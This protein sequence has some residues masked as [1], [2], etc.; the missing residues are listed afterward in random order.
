MTTKR[1]RRRSMMAAALVCGAVASFATTHV[2]ARAA[3]VGYDAWPGA[4]APYAPDTRTCTNG[5]VIVL[6]GPYFAC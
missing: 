5:V 1:V 3:T 4:G 6:F 2:G